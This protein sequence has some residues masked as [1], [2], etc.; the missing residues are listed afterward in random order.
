MGPIRPSSRVLS[1][2]AVS[3]S[4]LVSALVSVEASELVSELVSASELVC[5][6]DAQAAR[7]RTRARQSTRHRSLVS[8]FIFITSFSRI[9]IFSLSA[10]NT[11]KKNGL[12]GCGKA[13][14]ELPA[15]M[16]AGDDHGFAGWGRLIRTPR[17]INKKDPATTAESRPRSPAVIW[18]AQEAGAEAASA[19]HVE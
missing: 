9:S 11:R 7:L 1:P 8:F 14:I 3:A 17:R 5:S 10:Q 15:A 4:E 16:A 19:D 18:A 2:S 13:G 12:A 6:L